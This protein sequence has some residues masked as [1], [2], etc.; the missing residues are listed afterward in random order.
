MV[1]GDFAEERDTM[2]IGAGPGG[3]V[4]AIRAA[5]L[6][7]KVTVVEKEYIGGVCLNVGC[8]PSKALI[9]A[10]HRLQEAKDSKIFGIKNIQDPVLDFKVTQDWKDHQVVDRL[11][12]GVEMLLKKHKVEV[13]RGEAICMIIIPYG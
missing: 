12:G 1:V 6:G 3:Y 11:T 5:E 4:A 7:Q 9:S 8:I 2:I 10:G 13:V